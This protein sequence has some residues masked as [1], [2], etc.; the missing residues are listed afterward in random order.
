LGFGVVETAEGPLAADEVVHEEACFGVGGK[1]VVVALVDELLEVGEVFVRE[2]EGFGVDAG[3]EAVHGGDGL[4]CDRGG[5]GRFLGVA[6]I[7]F[8]LMDGRHEW[9]RCGQAQRV[10]RACP[11]LRIEERFREFGGEKL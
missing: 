9:L 8:N 2:D 6:A 7:G 4:A 5:A 1:V 3:F 11:A 10:P